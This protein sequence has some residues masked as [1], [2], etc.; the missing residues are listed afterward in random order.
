M[1]KNYGE[2]SEFNGLD[3]VG[4]SVKEGLLEDWEAARFKGVCYVLQ[5]LHGCCKNCCTDVVRI[6]A[7]VLLQGCCCKNFCCKGCCCEGVFVKI[8]V[9]RVFL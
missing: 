5:L 8:V 7:R 9:A 3:A 1:K 2:M 6:V 4:G